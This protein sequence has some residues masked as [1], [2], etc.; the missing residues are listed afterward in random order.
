MLL[1]CRCGAS[2]PSGDF[3]KE[4]WLLTL[5][6]LHLHITCFGLFFVF[7]FFFPPPLSLAAP[8]WSAKTGWHNNKWEDG[9]GGKLD[10]AEEGREGCNKVPL[11]AVKA[12]LGPLQ[13]VCSHVRTLVSFCPVGINTLQSHLVLSVPPPPNDNGCPANTA[14]LSLLFLLLYCPLK[15][16]SLT[17]SPCHAMCPSAI[18][19]LLLSVHLLMRRTRVRPSPLPQSHFLL[20]PP[21]AESP[22]LLLLFS[23]FSSSK[24]QALVTLTIATVAG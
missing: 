8:S 4:K 7:C 1:H 3:V 20:C 17:E 22:Q 6:F 13:W 18:A 19:L 23:T 21:S 16:P 14:F 2:A 24:Q 11:S 10:G 15:P 9:R 12:R 5:V